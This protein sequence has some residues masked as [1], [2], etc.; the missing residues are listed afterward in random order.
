[1]HLVS[2]VTRLINLV[3]YEKKNTF[4]LLGFATVSVCVTS[5]QAV[6]A[7][8]C[9]ASCGWCYVKQATRLSAASGRNRCGLCDFPSHHSASGH[10]SYGNKEELQNTKRSRLAQSVQCLATGWTTGDPGSILSRG[11]GFFL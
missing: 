9:N 1:M 8:L 6:M 10:R 3:F 5:H 2:C 4:V 7:V 11:K